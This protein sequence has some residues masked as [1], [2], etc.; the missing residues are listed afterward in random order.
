MNC[1]PL[2]GSKVSKSR[3]RRGHKDDELG[4]VLEG[5]HEHLGCLRRALDRREER[6][7]HELDELDAA[8][9]VECL[10]KVGNLADDLPCFCSARNPCE[11]RRKKAHL[12]ALRV[13]VVKAGHQGDLEA[14]RDGVRVE[15]LL[16]PGHGTRRCAVDERGRGRGAVRLDPEP[17]ELGQD[18]EPVPLVRRERVG[19][20]VVRNGLQH[21]LEMRL[22][23]CARAGVSPAGRV[24]RG[25]GSALSE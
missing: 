8:L 2:Q 22:V 9:L 25:E 16:E 1:L 17:E 10:E 18:G 7:G 6:A 12:E 21:G 5:S 23:L 4:R 24:S 19:R 13:A 15:E 3:S 11:P 14:E 20:D